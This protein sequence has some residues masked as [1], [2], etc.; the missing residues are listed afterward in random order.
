MRIERTFNSSIKA[1]LE[2]TIPS[3]DK[4]VIGVVMFEAK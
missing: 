3:K 2:R 1:T 4:V